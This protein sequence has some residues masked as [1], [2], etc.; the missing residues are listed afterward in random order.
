MTIL[1]EFVLPCLWAALACVGFA[2]VFNIHGF[3]IVI[4]A[5]G[6]ALGWLVYLLTIGPLD[7]DLLASFCA[8][9]AISLWSELMARLRKCPVTGY[10]TVAF[11]PL[12]PGGGIFYA[13]EHAIAGEID[14]FLSTLLH[15]LGLCGALAVGV[16]L[17][18]SVFRILTGA[19]RKRRHAP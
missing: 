5:G 15:T 3:G 1:T 12:V 8:G 4:C 14:A 16:L 10:L 13:M 2:L 7:S 6:G 11:F 19:A 18:S 9:I 17:V